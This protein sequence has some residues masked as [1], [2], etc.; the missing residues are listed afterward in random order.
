MAKLSTDI[1]GQV[2]VNAARIVLCCAK[3]HY[4]IA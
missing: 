2:V 4:V 1:V 3:H